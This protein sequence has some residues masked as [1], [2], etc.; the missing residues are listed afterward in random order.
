[1]R[2][3]RYE[4][5]EEEKELLKQHLIDTKPF[6]DYADPAYLWEGLVAEWYEFYAEAYVK[7][8]LRKG[9]AT[10]TNHTKCIDELGDVLW[11]TL[12]L[13]SAKTLP[14]HVPKNIPLQDVCPNAV[15]IDAVLGIIKDRGYTIKEVIEGNLNKLRGR[16]G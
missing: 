2:Q 9:D 4:I 15:R 1:M 13:P 16:H 12:R 14:T 11:F 8:I 5:T 6:E 10:C 7:P 3:C